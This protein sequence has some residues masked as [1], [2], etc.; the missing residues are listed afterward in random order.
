MGESLLDPARLIGHPLPGNGMHVVPLPNEPS[1]AGLRLH[2][3]G[4]LRENRLILTNGL[5]ITVGF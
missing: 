2:T 3:Q 1:L 4:A 5:H